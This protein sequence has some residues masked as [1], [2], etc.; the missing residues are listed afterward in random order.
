MLPF[1][2]EKFVPVNVHLAIKLQWKG[3]HLLVVSQNEHTPELN[4]A[5]FNSKIQKKMV[6][7]LLGQRVFNG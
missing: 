5:H 4:S 3:S 2:S 7:C 1:N 6:G